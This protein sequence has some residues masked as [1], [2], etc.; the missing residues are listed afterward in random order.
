[1][2]A[3]PVPSHREWQHQPKKTTDLLLIVWCNA[4]KETGTSTGVTSGGW[5]NTLITTTWKST[6]NSAIFATITRHWTHL[7]VGCFYYSNVTTLHILR[8]GLCYRKSVCHLSL[9]LSSETFLR[10]IPGVGAFGNIS[11]PFCTLA[12]LWPLCKILRRL[13]QEN[14]SDMGVKRKRG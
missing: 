10:P 6:W 11:L 1:M 7:F 8:S 3:F 9:C 13:S 14:P 5:K 2:P 4:G 12:I